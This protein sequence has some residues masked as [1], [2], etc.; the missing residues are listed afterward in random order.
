MEKCF[1]CDLGKRD[2]PNLIRENEEF[3]S[4]YDDSPVSPGHAIVIPKSHV[5]SFF[6][7]ESDQSAGLV[8]FIKE[9][10]TEI[11]IKYA[12]DA[13]NL[14]VNDG[15]AAGRSIDHLHIH[16]IPRYK[17]D[18]ENPRGGVRNLFG[19]YVPPEPLPEGY[20]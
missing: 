5:L 18:V 9:V 19:K 1:F 10:K 3:Y 17:G 12:P 4:I 16:L 8:E 15:R 14:G 6:E 2:K 11:D 13:Y 7:L 20:D